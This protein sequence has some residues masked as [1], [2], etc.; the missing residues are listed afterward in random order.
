MHQSVG[1]HEKT[2]IVRNE[3]RIGIKFSNQIWKDLRQGFATVFDAQGNAIAATQTLLPEVP[4]Q[5]RAEA[6]FVWN[7]PFAVP[8]GRIDI[9]PVVSL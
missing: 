1:R 6:V 8:A 2:K 3:G 4:P 9:V 7:E 5:G